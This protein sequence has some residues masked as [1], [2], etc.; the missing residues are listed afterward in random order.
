MNDPNR[1]ADPSHQP[2]RAARRQPNRR[3]TYAHFDRITTRWLDNDT[4]GHVNNVVYYSWF[5]TAVNRYL[6]DRG[7]L[8]IR[9]GDVIGFVVETH[10]EYFAPVAFP[11]VVHA[12]VR[13]ARIGSS[14]VRYEIGLFR[15]EDAT[16]AAQGHFVHV[17]VDRHSQRPV[18]LPSRMR[19]VLQQ[20]VV[21][22]NNDSSD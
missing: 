14:S 8:D 15:N 10:C 13:V 2:P 21:P 3:D 7:V 11:D 5:D 20:L 1:M 19:A 9:E 16:A 12:G 4:Y 17:Y 6:I 18:V 22:L